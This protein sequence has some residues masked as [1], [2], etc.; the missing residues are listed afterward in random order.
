MLSIPNQRAEKQRLNSKGETESHSAADDG[1]PD[2]YTLMTEKLPALLPRSKL[3]K[4]CEELLG[5]KLIGKSTLEKLD[6]RNEGPP[7]I[8]IGG[9]FTI[10]E[11][12]LS[13]GIEPGCPLG[14]GKRVHTS[15]REKFRSSCRS[16]LGNG[17]C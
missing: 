12:H 15:V 17:C 3:P 13:D 14:Q 11:V 16:I 9:G 6:M 2:I 5:T 10:D 1:T 8:K 4:I 7:K